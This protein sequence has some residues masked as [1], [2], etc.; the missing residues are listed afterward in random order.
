V[1]R[2][3]RIGLRPLT[4]ASRFG[5]D[6]SGFSAVEFALVL[7]L[8]MLL[9][10]GGTELG[11]ALTI[12]RK[13]T[14]AA[15]ALGDLVAQSRT[16]SDHDMDDILDAVTAIIAP[17]DQDKLRIRVTGVAIDSK[18]KATVAWSDARNDI[19]AVMG[20]AVSLPAGVGQPNSFVVATEVHYEYTPAYGYVMTGSFDLNHSF[21]LRPRAGDKVERVAG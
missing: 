3:E 8:M 18:G 21:H 5:R 15:S 1:V 19:P 2:L 12:D 13:V 7:P 4:T 14:H 20:T 6:R 16:I 10:L 17:Y 11:D 9:F